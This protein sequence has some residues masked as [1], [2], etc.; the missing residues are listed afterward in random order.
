[1]KLFTEMLPRLNTIWSLKQCLKSESGTEF[2]AESRGTAH[3]QGVGER[4]PLKLQNYR[5]RSLRQVTYW[6]YMILVVVADLITC[7]LTPQKPRRWSFGSASKR[8]WPLLTIQGTPLERV[9]VYKLLG[10]FNYFCLPMLGN[11]YW[12]YTNQTHEH[13][14]MSW[15]SKAG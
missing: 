10:V 14:T 1:M 4:S 3:G 13:Q 2:S 15:N 12:L 6:F 9:S 8:Y 5:N 7:K 11:T